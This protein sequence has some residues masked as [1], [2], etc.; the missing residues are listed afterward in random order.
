LLQQEALSSGLQLSQLAVLDPGTL[1]VVPGAPLTRREASLQQA[2][3]TLFPEALL[4]WIPLG[5]LWKHNPG[6]VALLRPQPLG[7]GAQSGA[8]SVGPFLAVNPFLAEPHFFCT[9]PNNP[10]KHIKMQLWQQN[11][12]ATLKLHQVVC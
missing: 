1:P 12:N 4:A 2:Q 11:P 6:F 8:E 10:P 5:S 3:P 7:P 9:F